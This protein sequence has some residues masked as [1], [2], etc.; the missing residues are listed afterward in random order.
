[1]KVS[2]VV[3]HIFMQRD[4]LPQ[5]IFSPGVL[6]LWLADSLVAQGVDVTLFTPGPVDTKATNVTAD[7]SPFQRELDGRG[8]TYLEL[9]KKHPLTFISLARQVQSQLIADAFQ[10]ANDNREASRDWVIETRGDLVPQRRQAIADR[11]AE[12]AAK[13]GTENLDPETLKAMMPP[14]AE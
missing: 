14:P 9:L 4:I 13:Y 8:D 5:V 7:L 6:A 3:P 1:M 12:H 11:F 2:I 10:Q